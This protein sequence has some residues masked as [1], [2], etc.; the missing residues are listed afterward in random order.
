MKSNETARDNARE[1]VLDAAYAL[2]TAHGVNQ[3]GI[4]RILA[5]AGCAKASLY[6]HFH[7]KS[8]LAVAFLDRREE[9][10]TRDWLQAQIMRRA[11]MPEKRLLAIFDVF[12]AWFRKKD[13][14]GC[15][16]V[17]VLLES[18]GTPLHRAAAR[19]LWKIRAFIRTLAEDAGLQD[20]DKFAAAW[21]ML[22]KGSIS[23]AGEGNHNAAR[24]A[25]RAAR[26]ILGGWPRRVSSRAA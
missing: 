13:F 24:E 9:I 11:Q 21:H 18:R 22:M 26:M 10:W 15:S 23:A 14:E 2:F 19:H 5:K 16:F 8:D 4:D 25:K 1:R 3:V 20:P 17:N 12:D 6:T 7:S